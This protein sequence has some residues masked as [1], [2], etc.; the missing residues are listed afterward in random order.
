LTKWASLVPWM[1]RGELDAIKTRDAILESSLSHSEK[2]ALTAIF[3]HWHPDS[4]RPRPGLRRLA[5][6]CSQKPDTVLAAIRSLTRRGILDV[7]EHTRQAHEYVLDNVMQGLLAV[8]PIG[9]EELGAAAPA[10]VPSIGTDTSADVSRSG[11]HAVPIQGAELSR[12][13]ERKQHLKQDLKRESQLGWLKPPSDFVFN[14]EDRKAEEEAKDLGGDDFNVELSRK[15]WLKGGFRRPVFDLHA[16]YQRWVL[17]DGERAS[18]RQMSPS[19]FERVQRLAK[20]E[21]KARA[22]AEARREREAR[23]PTYK[24]AIPSIA[25]VLKRERLR[26]A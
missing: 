11:E 23:S 10:A 18:R 25:D 14:D 17:E 22:V 16:H 20:E 5:A 24:A 19:S 13:R 26:S 12:S 1:R 15:K 7:V 3:S 21:R 9:T 4:P 8:P 6:L 2:S